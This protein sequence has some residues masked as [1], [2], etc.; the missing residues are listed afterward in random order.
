M[1]KIIY[2]SHCLGL[3]QAKDSSGVFSE[4]EKSCF[5]KFNLDEFTVDYNMKQLYM[6]EDNILFSQFMA[7]VWKKDGFIDHKDNLDFSAFQK[8]ISETFASVVASKK[9]ADAFARDSVNSCKNVKGD[10]PGQKGIKFMNCVTRLF[11]N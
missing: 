11:Q 7:C 3:F 5:K 2:F 10:T 4:V 1:W 9:T 8:Y 6:P